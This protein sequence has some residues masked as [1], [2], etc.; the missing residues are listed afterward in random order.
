MD[1]LI[2]AVAQYL[3]YL[4]MV[5]AGVI[6]LF[7]PRHDKVGQAVQAMVSAQVFDPYLHS[8]HTCPTVQATF[9]A[10]ARP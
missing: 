1:S 3:I 7:L 6:W 9:D 10:N 2:A 4:I 5:A 8:I